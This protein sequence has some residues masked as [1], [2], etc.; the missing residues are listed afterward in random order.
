MKRVRGQG[1]VLEL[2]RNFYELFFAIAP[3]EHELI[4]IGARNRQCR[5][6]SGGDRAETEIG[7][8]T[9]LDSWQP[10]VHPLVEARF[11]QRRSRQNVNTFETR[12]PG[13]Q[14]EV[15]EVEPGRIGN[16]IAQRHDDLANRRG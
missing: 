3:D 7:G 13:Q 2:A 5:P 16:P 9:L 4:A 10:L 6:G 11:E 12:Q 8:F 14:V 15:G 1:G